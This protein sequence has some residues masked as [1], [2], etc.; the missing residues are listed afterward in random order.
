MHVVGYADG[1]YGDVYRFL[2]INTEKD[3]HEQRYKVAQHNM[4][5]LQI[6]KYLCKKTSGTFPG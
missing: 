1:H 3:Y 4:E 5:T 2:N 6:V